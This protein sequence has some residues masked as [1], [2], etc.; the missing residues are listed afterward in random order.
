ME[1]QKYLIA[2]WRMIV[3][4]ANWILLAYCY[5]S[6]TYVKLNNERMANELKKVALQI[7][8]EGTEDYINSQID[9]K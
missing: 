8:E 2:N 7:K 4:I 1:R 3:P 6:A 5:L 9:R